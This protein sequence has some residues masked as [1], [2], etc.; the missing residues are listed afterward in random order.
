MICILRNLNFVQPPSSGWDRLPPAGEN[1]LGAY[2]TRIKIY[3][4]TLCHTSKTG[5][6]DKAFNKIKSNLIHVSF[7]SLKSSNGVFY[8]LIIT[9]IPYYMISN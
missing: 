7:T 6:N 9:Q 5:I 3:R 2:L 4:N 8:K 1:S